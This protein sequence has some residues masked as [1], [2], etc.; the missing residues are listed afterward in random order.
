MVYPVHVWV[1]GPV[2]LQVVT[3]LCVAWPLDLQVV[4]PLC[5]L[6]FTQILCRMAVKLVMHPPSQALTLIIGSTKDLHL[7]PWV[8]GMWIISICQ[9]LLSPTDNIYIQDADKVR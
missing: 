7:S 5:G 8:G 2:D 6:M 9:A 3:W 4:T 1:S